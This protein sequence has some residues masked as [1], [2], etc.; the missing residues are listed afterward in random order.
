MNI[1]ESEL[2]P[3]PFCASPCDN[4]VREDGEGFLGCENTKCPV[5][6]LAMTHDQ[7]NT[8]AYNKDLNDARRELEEV[9]SAILKFGYED[10]TLA[11]MCERHKLYCESQTKRLSE[12][13]SL[14]VSLSN[15]LGESRRELDS[16]QV[17]LQMMASAKLV[18]ELNCKEQIDQLQKSNAVM[19]EALMKGEKALNIC[20]ADA[21][22]I[23]ADVLE[24]GYKLPTAANAIRNIRRQS[25]QFRDLKAALLEQ[26]PTISILITREEIE[27]LHCTCTYIDMGHKCPRCQLIE[28]HFPH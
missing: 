27:A 11:S 12:S 9:K 18:N 28:K 26:L 21:C 3:C 5:S 4:C 23:D 24:N 15:K 1:N 14:S 8:R 13:T 7:W 17:D 25:E 22:Y 2:K 19:R 6:R 10:G 20:Y 16:V